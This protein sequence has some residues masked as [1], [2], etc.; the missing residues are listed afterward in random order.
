[1]FVEHLA[2]TSDPRA[3][4]AVEELSNEPDLAETMKRLNKKFGRK[5]GV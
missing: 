5:R 3:R 4:A 2:D 1:M